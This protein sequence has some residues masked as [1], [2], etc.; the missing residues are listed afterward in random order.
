VENIKTQ[1]FCSENNTYMMMKNKIIEDTEK[2]RD[3]KPKII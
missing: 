1:F 2:R 3:Q